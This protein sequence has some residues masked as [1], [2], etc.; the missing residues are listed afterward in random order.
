MEYALSRPGVAA[1]MVGSRSQQEMQAA[2]EWCTASDAE[3]DYASTLSGLDKFTWHGHCMYC[4]HCAP[5]T[6]GI[7]I[8]SVN[9]FRNL[10]PAEGPIPETVR[11]HYGALSHH[12]SECVACGACES[13]CPFG[14]EIVAAMRRAAE[15]FGQ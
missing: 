6:V 12:A 7:D 10:C 3:K 8:A 1:V 11:E 9:K 14:V 4:G 15:Y 5:C 13:R 2:L